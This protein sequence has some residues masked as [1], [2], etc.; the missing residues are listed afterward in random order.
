MPFGSGCVD[1]VPA[2]FTC[3]IGDSCT[4]CSPDGL[5]CEVCAAGYLRFGPTCLQPPTAACAA[6]TDGTGCKTCG[7][8]EA[9]QTC[10]DTERTVPHE[11]VC[12]PVPPC[13]EGMNKCL[14][15]SFNQAVCVECDTADLFMPLG[16]GCV[17]K[18]CA[19]NSYGCKTCL[20]KLCQACQVATH[21]PFGTSCVDPTTVA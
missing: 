11:S 9:C 8:R 18:N 5:K 6:L 12:V 13:V 14:K 19:A 15:C 17:P 16:P 3:S 4:K 2:S 20:P 21:V 7:N 1:K 10:V